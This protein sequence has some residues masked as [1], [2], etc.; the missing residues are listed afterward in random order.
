M[1]TDKARSV[2]AVAET[3]TEGYLW[4]STQKPP[5]WCQ[6]HTQSQCLWQSPNT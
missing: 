6:F 2:C 5:T 3:Y 4:E 1:D